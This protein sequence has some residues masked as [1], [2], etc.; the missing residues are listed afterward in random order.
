MNASIPGYNLK[1]Y[2]ENNNFD[3]LNIT[4]LSMNDCY[5]NLW[6]TLYDE[7]NNKYITL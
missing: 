5:H 6:L 3:K 2:H 7:D 4:K 1:K